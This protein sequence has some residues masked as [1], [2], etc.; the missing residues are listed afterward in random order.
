MGRVARDTAASTTSAAD[1]WD[2]AWELANRTFSQFHDSFLGLVG[3]NSDAELMTKAQEQFNTFE[4]SLRTNVAK[5]SEEVRL[6]PS[7]SDVK[8]RSSNTNLLK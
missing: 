5:L 8:C 4:S 6:R 7:L 2:S 1:S 3:V